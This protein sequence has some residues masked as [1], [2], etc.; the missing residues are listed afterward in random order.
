MSCE[1]FVMF[2]ILLHSREEFQI[3]TFPLQISK[4]KY[5]SHKYITWF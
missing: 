2:L 3:E 5:S 1:I 4:V